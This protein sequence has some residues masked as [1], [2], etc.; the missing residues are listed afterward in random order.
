[1]GHEHSCT[2]PRYGCTR[3]PAA[4]RLVGSHLPVT[5]VDHPHS[6]TQRLGAGGRQL[7]SIMQHLKSRLRKSRSTKDRRNTRT[8]QDTAQ[9]GGRRTARLSSFPHS[10]PPDLPTPPAFSPLGR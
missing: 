6:H 4:T 8:T 3:T 9:P 7:G 2:T 5:A 10:Q 1:M